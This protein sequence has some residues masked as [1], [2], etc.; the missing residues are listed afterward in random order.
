M[1]MM[2]RIAYR[3]RAHDLYL[4]DEWAMAV[5]D[6]GSSTRKTHGGGSSFERRERLRSQTTAPHR[7]TMAAQ[8]DDSAESAGW[9]GHGGVDGEDNSSCG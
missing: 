3:L 2:M 5:A 6:K 4:M 9:L 8:H 7:T 1:W